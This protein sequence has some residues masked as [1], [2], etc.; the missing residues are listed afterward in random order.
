MKRSNHHVLPVL[1]LLLTASLWGL[2]WYPLRL[3]EGQGLSGLWVTLSSYG[4]ALVL[5]APLRAR[6]LIVSI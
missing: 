5:V 4:A 1:S 2:V 6:I 3:L